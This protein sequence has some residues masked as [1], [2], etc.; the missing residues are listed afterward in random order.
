MVDSIYLEVNSAAYALASEE[1]QE[2]F[3]GLVVATLIKR[4]EQANER[5]IEIS[6]PARKSIRDDSE[7]EFGLVPMGQEDFSPAD[8]SGQ[9]GRPIYAHSQSRAE[10][11]GRSIVTTSRH[12]TP[13]VGAENVTSILFSSDGGVHVVDDKRTPKP[14]SR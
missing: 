3:K 11:A 13:P 8:D 5:L 10:A 14:P 12:T 7:F 6:R 1:C 4:T 2:H 9:S